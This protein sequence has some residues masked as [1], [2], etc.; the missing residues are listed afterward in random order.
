MPVISALVALIWYRPSRQ[1]R[2]F[3]TLLHNIGCAQALAQHIARPHTT[4]DNISC[5]SRPACWQT[6]FHVRSVKQALLADFFVAPRTDM[7]H[8]QDGVPIPVIHYARSH[9]DRC[10]KVEV[11]PLSSIMIGHYNSYCVYLF[12]FPLGIIAVK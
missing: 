2:L 4:F 7:L 1:W 8:M 11:L 9:R 12:Q 6:W 10:F 3:H 5:N